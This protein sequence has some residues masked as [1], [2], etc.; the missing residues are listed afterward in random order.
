MAQKFLPEEIEFMIDLLAKSGFFS[1]DEIMEILEDQFMEEEIDFS[2]FNIS[3][4][5]A[6]IGRASCR[7]RV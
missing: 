1:A 6:K 7:E 4:T 2:N 3:L 5:A